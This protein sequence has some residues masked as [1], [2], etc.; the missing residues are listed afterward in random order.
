[1]KGYPDINLVARG[2]KTS[3][4]FS[5]YAGGEITAGQ[6]AA[7]TGFKP[8]SM[9]YAA[10][11]GYGPEQWAEMQRGI[12]SQIAGGSAQAYGALAQSHGG[13][14]DPQAIKAIN[15]RMA[16]ARMAAM[17]ELERGNLEYRRQA[18]SAW[19]EYKRQRRRSILGSVLDV[20]TLGIYGGLKGRSSGAPLQVGDLTADPNLLQTMTSGGDLVPYFPDMGFSDTGSGW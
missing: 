20:I 11:V 10:T 13:F 6:W 15:T 17:A 2:A 9:Q 16:A 5:Q 4:A 14:V 1:M 7:A 8:G 3:K 18:R 19:D 12:H